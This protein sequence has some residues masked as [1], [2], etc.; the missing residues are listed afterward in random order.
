MSYCRNCGLDN[1][2]GNR[3]CQRCG[4]ELDM[5]NQ[6]PRYAYPPQTGAQRGAYAAVPNQGQPRYQN[7]APPQ[8]VYHQSPPVQQKYQQA[9]PQQ[10]QPTPVQN[11]QSPN[12]VEKPQEAPAPQPE[13]PKEDK[14]GYTIHLSGHESG[15]LSAY[16]HFNNISIEEFIKK[17]TIEKLRMEFAKKSAENAYNIFM[18]DRTTYT[19]EEVMGNHDL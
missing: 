14:G 18:G 8:Y 7:Q 9:P 3:Y 12:Y 2:P 16:A 15:L 5:Y 10:I 17:A 19:L 4:S 1:I 6:E 11:Y 13:A